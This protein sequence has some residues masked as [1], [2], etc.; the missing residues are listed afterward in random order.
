MKAL[1]EETDCDEKHCQHLVC[2]CAG[3]KSFNNLTDDTPIAIT[4]PSAFPLFLLN[5]HCFDSEKMLTLGKFSRA[6][7][8]LL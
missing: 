4:H 2:V 7:G 3:S 8:E 1:Y 6:N 5:G